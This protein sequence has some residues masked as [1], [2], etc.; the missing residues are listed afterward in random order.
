MRV[1]AGLRCRAVL[2]APA[3]P[4]LGADFRLLRI[5]GLSSEM[6]RA[7]LGAGAEV[8]YGFVT[9]RSASP[10]RSTAGEM[11]PMA[12]LARPGTGE[13]AR[14]ERIAAEAFAMWSGAAD[15]RFRRAAPAERPD[16]LIGAQAAPRRI[17]F[18]NVWHEAEAARGR[19]GAAGARDDLLQ[20]RG[21]VVDGPGSPRAGRQDL[22]TTLAHEI[23]HAIGL[24]HPGAAGTMMGYRG[25]GSAVGLKSGDVAGARALY[26]RLRRRSRA[27]DARPERRARLRVRRIRRSS[28]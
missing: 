20:P 14:L 23:G 1:L 9:E 24:D 10:T 26:G 5:D 16:I 17:A 28:P 2:L 8:S 6:G 15:V 4:A 21:R 27:V 3:L 11:A 25:P 18:A 22:R 13:S 12:A 7:G 19:R